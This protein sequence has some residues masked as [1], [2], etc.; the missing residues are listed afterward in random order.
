M[1][2]KR[3]T[4]SLEW[5]SEASAFWLLGSSQK[6]DFR[7]LNQ[8][9]LWSR[10]LKPKLTRSHQELISANVWLETDRRY[11]YNRRWSDSSVILW[12][13][14]QISDWVKCRRAA[15]SRLGVKYNSRFT[16]MMTGDSTRRSQCTSRKLAFTSSHFF[17]A[18]FPEAPC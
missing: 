1:G 3:Y 2:W 7:H 6:E 18:S 5:L 14:V 12:S 4:W 13:G 11:F 17:H 15:G 16:G 10:F 9:Q 8:S